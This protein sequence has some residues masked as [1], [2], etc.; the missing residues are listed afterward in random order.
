VQAVPLPNTVLY[1]A[2]LKT[3]SL[4]HTTSCLCIFALSPRDIQSQQT[5]KYALNRSVLNGIIHGYSLPKHIWNRGEKQEHEIMK[6]IYKAIHYYHY[7]K[8]KLKQSLNMSSWYQE[9]DAS[10][11]Y[12]KRQIK[13]VK[14]SALRNC[15]IYTP[16]DIL[17][18]QFRYRLSRPQGVVWSEG[19]CQ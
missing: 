9:C 2:L 16:A 12:D 11:C 17:V 13:V 18:T 3:T 7:V 1:Q 5:I 19:L 6:I 4:S 14:L 15:S 10:R 8:K